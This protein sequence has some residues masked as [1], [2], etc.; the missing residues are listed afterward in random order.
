MYPTDAIA[1]HPDLPGVMV[2][3]AFR[4]AGPL[5]T[6]AMSL[7]TST[8]ALTALQR[9]RAWVQ[10]AAWNARGDEA[11]LWREVAERIEGAITATIARSWS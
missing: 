9:A 11:R 3:Y 2:V 10:E 6:E 4:V 1:P 5:I 7:P 8:E